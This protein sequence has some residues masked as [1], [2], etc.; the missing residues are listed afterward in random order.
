VASIRVLLNYTVFASIPHVLPGL[1]RLSKT[2][3]SNSFIFLSNP[4]AIAAYDYNEQQYG[5]RMKSCEV[6]TNKG[7]RQSHY[8]FNITS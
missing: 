6:T 5:L 7:Y 2:S 3:S 4:L 1:K 8:D